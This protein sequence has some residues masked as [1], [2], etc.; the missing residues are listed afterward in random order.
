MSRNPVKKP[1]RGRGRPPR[2]YSDDLDLEIAE[3]SA[4]L[5]A[6]W[7]LSERAAIDLALAICQGEP[8]EPSKIPRGARAGLLVGYTLPLNRRFDGRNA[9]V[10][11]KLK[12]G[13]LRP[14]AE[15]VLKIARLL[16][17][18]RTLPHLMV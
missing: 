9:D 14:H 13:K 11:R 16:L 5:R 17:R 3:W 8:G 4:A 2:D 6:A 12:A 7:G 10:R 15:L 1:R 18:I